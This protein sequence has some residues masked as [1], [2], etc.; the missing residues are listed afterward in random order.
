MQERDTRLMRGIR[1]MAETLKARAEL[2]DLTFIRTPGTPASVE[3][4][5]AAGVKCSRDAPDIGSTSYCSVWA[6]VYRYAAWPPTLT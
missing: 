6:A 3:M 2:D 1:C 4:S 5:V